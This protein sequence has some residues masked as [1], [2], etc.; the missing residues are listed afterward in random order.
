MGQQPAP[1]GAMARPRSAGRRRRG[2]AHDSTLYHQFAHLYDRFFA[3]VYVRGLRQVV[4]A[5]GL[6]PGARVL[7]LGV[8]T[9]LSLEAYPRNVAVVGIDYSA[10]MLEEAQ[11]RV[12]RAGLANVE[13]L[14]MSACDL[15]LPDSSFDFVLAFHVVTVV[16]EADALMREALRVLKPDGRLVVVNRFRRERGLMG[17][18]ERRLEP[19][20]KRCGWKTLSRR[21]LLDGHPLEVL[22]ARKESPTS[23]FTTVVAVNRKHR[24]NGAAR[25]NGH[26][27]GGD[28]AARRP[29]P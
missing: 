19:L 16:P 9:G 8:G 6:P 14:Q 3:P 11:R 7:E 22:V 15:R 28:G 24:L 25:L 23:L 13:L 10:A 17:R 18:I 12:E 21:E 29:C 5:L 20:W 4:R 26:A 1:P 27:P 2:E